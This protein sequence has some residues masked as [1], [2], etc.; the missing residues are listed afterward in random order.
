MVPYIIL[1]LRIKH[2]CRNEVRQEDYEVEV[3]LGYRV[4]S[5]LRREKDRENKVT[6]RNFSIR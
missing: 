3:S 2:I 4:E 5:Y 6:L 1:R